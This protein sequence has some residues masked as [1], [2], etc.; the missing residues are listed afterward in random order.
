[1]RKKFTLLMVCILCGIS[2]SMAQNITVKGLVKDKQGLP[3]PGVSVKVKGT[4]QGAS[5]A[6]N[7]GYTI[8]AP[9][10]STL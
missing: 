5:T 2:L 7:G 10:N 3:L 8:S 1:M 6:D 4:N 9:Q